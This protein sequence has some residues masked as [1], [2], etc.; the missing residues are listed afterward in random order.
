MFGGDD[1]AL[2]APD[3][4]SIEYV[5]EYE[6]VRRNFSVLELGIGAEFFVFQKVSFVFHGSYFGGFQDIQRQTAIFQYE[7]GSL[8][9]GGIVMDGSYLNVGV[10]VAYPISDIWQKKKK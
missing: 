4:T 7:D 1:L 5:V 3:G 2:L 6:D 9:T 10:T 8:R